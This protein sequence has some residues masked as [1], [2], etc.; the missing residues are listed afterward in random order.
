MQ[1]RVPSLSLVAL[2][3]ALLVASNPTG[4][5][6][7]SPYTRSVFQPGQVWTY[8]TRPGEEGSR[9]IIGRVESAP[10]IGT[11]VHI[12]VV[13]VAVKNPRS[14]KGVSTEISHIPMTE[15]A[16]ADS[17][18]ERVQEELSL[19]GFEEGY[20]AWRES[21]DQGRGAAFSDPVA[22]VIGLVEQTLNR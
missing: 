1:R 22:D 4:P 2:V 16:L 3:G 8:K 18:R 19:E 17:V 5:P 9:I 12:K 21:W 20:A 15:E 14:P 13:G 10:I 11:I 7:L 6:K